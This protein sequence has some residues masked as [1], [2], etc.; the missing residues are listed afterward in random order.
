MS[1]RLLDAD[2]AAQL[3]AMSRRWVLAEARADRI[4]H[5][6]LGRAVRFDPDELMTWARARA[7]GPIR[8]PPGGQGVR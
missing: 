2:G 8:R 1:G 5:M 4:P 7:R 3:L 6:R